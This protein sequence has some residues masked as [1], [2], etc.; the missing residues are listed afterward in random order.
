MYRAKTLGK[1]R[2]EVFDRTMHAAAVAR[3][4]FEGDLRHAI[5]RE[6]L[7][8]YYQP[9]VSIAD[10]RITGLEA[11][12]RWQHPERGLLPPA[13]FISLAE[14]TGLIMALGEWVLRQA[15]RQARA[16]RQ[17]FPNEPP[18]IVSVNISAKQLAR[19]DLITQTRRIL[20]ETGVDPSQIKLELTES[21]AME[22]A[23]RTRRTLHELKQLGVQLAIDDFGTGYSSLSYLRRFP[24]DTLKIDR[25]FVTRM[26]HDVENLEIVRAILGLARNLGMDVVAEGAEAAGEVSHLKVLECDYAQ[27]YFFSKPVDSATI[28][29]LLKRQAAATTS[30]PCA[31]PTTTADSTPL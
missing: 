1:A 2:Y 6:E 9:I 12:V 25:S 31:S 29:V 27:G 26:D 14:E 18:L 20:Q 24:I 15:C 21:A 17:V 10:K 22:N 7:R 3:L 30:G 16:W 28:E 5:E 8:V 19:H 4:Q 23:E 13:Q 11:L